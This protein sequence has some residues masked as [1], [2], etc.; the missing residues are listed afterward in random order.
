LTKKQFRHDFLRGLGSALI[1]LKESDDPKRYREIVIYGCLHNTTYDQ[2]CEP[3]R[4]W[5]LYEA[6][7]LLDEVKSIEQLVIEK[8]IRMKRD[9]WLFDQLTA[10]LYQFAVN[11]SSDARKALYQQYNVM[12]AE[13]S[14]KR[15]FTA[16]CP[17]RDMFDWICVWLTS[18]HGKRAFEKIVE[19]IS[20]V[21]LPKNVDFFF[22]EWFYVN[23]VNKFGE[24]YV[25]N[26]LEKRAETLP[27]VRVYYEKAKEQN[28][29][30]DRNTEQAIPTLEQVLAEAAKGKY[31]GRG[32]AIHF[33]R[34]AN[35]DEVEKLAKI[36]MDETDEQVKVEL[37][38]AFRR[39]GDF[40]FPETF[41]LK[42]S[43]SKNDELRLIAIGIMGKA[44]TDK[45][46]EFA[47]SLIRHG[48][49]VENGIALLSKNL[50]RKDEALLYE[51]VKS[52]P[53][54]RNG[55]SNWHSVFRDARAGIEKMRGQ[56]QTDILEY[57]YR[58][59][60]CSF[61]RE[62]DVRLMHKKKVLSKA[63]LQECRFDA[64]DDLAEFAKQV[65]MKSEK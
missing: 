3:H 1:A 49:D 7:T 40:N 24:D 30:W 29:R 15:K 43:Q 9:T 59:T 62:G 16:M 18:L 39:W 65:M 20:E 27:A 32:L 63:I 53:V 57:L 55:N 46:R 19:N 21:L 64:N 34:R 58:E 5:Y 48:T 12:L 13:L 33:V 31:R 60:L 44:P 35:L 26:Y 14:R 6:I 41:L 23:S 61:C 52:I 54:D 45:T 36:A 4:N 51:V 56:P 37:L 50:R 2:Q 11:G 25:T 42:L 8:F 28:K 17:R 22:D 47:L 10:L 38:Y